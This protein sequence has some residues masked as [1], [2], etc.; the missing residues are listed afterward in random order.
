M[1]FPENLNKEKALEQL[2]GTI[3]NESAKW[4]GHLAIKMEL[5]KDFVETV[6]DEETTRAYE[7]AERFLAGK[8]QKQFMSALGKLAEKERIAY[9]TISEYKFRESKINNA[10]VH[11]DNALNKINSCTELKK[12]ISE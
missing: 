12:L 3:E 10:N 1:K 6:F 7:K 5:E 11:M 4:I 9:N 2:N 8:D